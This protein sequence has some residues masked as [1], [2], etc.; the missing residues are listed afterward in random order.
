MD[1]QPYHSPPGQTRTGIINASAALAWVG[2]P[3]ANFLIQ[4]QHHHGIE[5]LINLLGP[6]LTAAL[7][8]A[9]CIEANLHD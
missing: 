4:N 3:F 2:N 7:A 8:L 5:G 9:E 6:E 1:F